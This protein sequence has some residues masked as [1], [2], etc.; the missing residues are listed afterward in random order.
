MHRVLHYSC[1][2]VH[3][4]SWQCKCGDF[5]VVANSL[6]K[7]AARS[8]SAFETIARLRMLVSSAAV[9]MH[10]EHISK[11]TVDTVQCSL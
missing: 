11:H 10:T 3:A 5:A 6:E 4:C 2:L 1:H 7:V 8:F 9:S